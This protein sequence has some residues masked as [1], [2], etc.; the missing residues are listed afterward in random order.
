[1]SENYIYNDNPIRIPGKT[2]CLECYFNLSKINKDR[3]M[4]GLKLKFNKEVENVKS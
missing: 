1:M 4:S 3:F 2:I